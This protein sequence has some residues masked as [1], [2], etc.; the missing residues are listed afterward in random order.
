M[1]KPREHKQE[2]NRKLQAIV[3]K[4]EAHVKKLG[5][6]LETL[7]RKHTSATSE[8]KQKRTHLE[9]S[10]EL[11]RKGDLQVRVF[12]LERRWM[13]FGDVRFWSLV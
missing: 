5:A 12:S 9:S 11:V 10:N 3:E 1:L 4:T 2:A 7:Q 13:R 8:L 6:D